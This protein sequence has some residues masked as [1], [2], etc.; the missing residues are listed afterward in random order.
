[1]ITLPGVA[2]AIPEIHYFVI[3]GEE[4]GIYILNSAGDD[5]VSITV[6]KKYVDEKIADFINDVEYDG[7]DGSLKFKKP[8]GEDVTINLP[9]D[10]FLSAASFDADSNILTLEL[11][12]GSKVDVPLSELVNLYTGGDTNSAK[13]SVSEEGVITAEVLIS[14]DEGNAL[15]ERENGLFIKAIP[16]AT[17]ITEG[18]TNSEAASAKFVYEMLKEMAWSETA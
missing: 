8:N 10:N 18:S 13:V 4:A 1:M 11:V 5:F 16:I 6:T 17:E 2:D 7:E 9:K 15:E 12:D 3:S 14:E